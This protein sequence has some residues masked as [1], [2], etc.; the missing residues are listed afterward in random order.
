MKCDDF[1][2]LA[3]FA[4][5]PGHQ[6]DP[7]AELVNVL[8]ATMFTVASNAPDAM[9]ENTDCHYRTHYGQNLKLTSC[10]NGQYGGCALN[11]AR[12]Q[13]IPRNFS[14]TASFG[15]RAKARRCRKST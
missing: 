2:C 9:S 10:K 13:R 5:A 3:T 1:G 6:D 8:L 7:R 15:C 14:S 12:C 11:S 4:V